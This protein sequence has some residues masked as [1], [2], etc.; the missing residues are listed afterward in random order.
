MSLASPVL[1]A[2]G[3][4]LSTH[5]TTRPLPALAHGRI[6]TRPRRSNTGEG[7]AACS[8]AA[9]A[10]RVAVSQTCGGAWVSL[11]SSMYVRTVYCTHSQFWVYARS[12]PRHHP[13]PPTTARDPFLPSIH[14]SSIS[15]H[16]GAHSRYPAPAPPRRS[17]HVESAPRA[18]DYRRLWAGVR[19]LAFH[20]Q[21]TANPPSVLMTTSR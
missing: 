9:V 5:H 1:L 3:L 13:W 20:P 10:V 6:H 16:G 8:A 21:P 11:A 17:S 19:G 4:A 15:A 12:R 18:D 2:Q 14:P 7:L